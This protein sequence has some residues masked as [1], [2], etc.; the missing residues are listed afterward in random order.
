VYL[1][2]HCRV[3]KKGVKYRIKAEY[4]QNDET[5]TEL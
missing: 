3:L 2:D 5:G 1:Y 4:N